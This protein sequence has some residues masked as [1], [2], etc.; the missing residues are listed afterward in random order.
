MSGTVVPFRR[1]SRSAAPGPGAV[2]ITLSVDAGDLVLGFDDCEV[3]LSPAQA[4][5]LAR[6]LLELALDAEAGRG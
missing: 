5:E 6:D 4:R 3:E 2:A 1:P